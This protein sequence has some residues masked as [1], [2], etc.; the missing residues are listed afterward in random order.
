MV[1]TVIAYELCC[2]S[3]PKLP[4]ARTKSITMFVNGGTQLRVFLG[5][6]CKDG[7]PTISPRVAQK[8]VNFAAHHLFALVER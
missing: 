4:R 2:G 1:R 6:S 8:D 7:N 5:H 3:S